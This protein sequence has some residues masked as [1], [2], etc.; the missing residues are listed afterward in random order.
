L[1][2]TGAVGR[3]VGAMALVLPVPALES[4]EEME[5]WLSALVRD[6]I[7]PLVR[8]GAKVV[9]GLVVVAVLIGRRGEA[10]GLLGRRGGRS[11]LGGQVSAGEDELWARP[12]CHQFQL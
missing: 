7:L 3:D 11:V 4:T 6:S 10:I 8:A 1:G 2:F 9:V 12:P 5:G